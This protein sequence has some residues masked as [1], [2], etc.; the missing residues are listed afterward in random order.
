MKFLKNTMKARKGFTMI[1][2]IFVIVILGIIVT[3][4]SNIFGGNVKY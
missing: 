1:E 4:G 3:V 2:L